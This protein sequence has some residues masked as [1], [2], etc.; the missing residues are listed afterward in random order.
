MSEGVRRIAPV[1]SRPLNT[2]RVRLVPT[3]PLY[4]PSLDTCCVQYRDA[5]RIDLGQ[6][7]RQ[8]KV[9]YTKCKILKLKEKLDY[10]FCIFN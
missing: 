2:L 5:Y 4:T 6:S 9:K 10:I 3:A 1:E 8:S 7:V